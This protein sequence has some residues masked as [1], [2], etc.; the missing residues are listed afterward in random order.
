MA[1]KQKKTAARKQKKAK[2]KKPDIVRGPLGRAKKRKKPRPRHPK[3]APR[4]ID[5]ISAI[6]EAYVEVESLAQEM[7]DWAD[8]MEDKLSGTQKYGEVNDAADTLE[9]VTNPVQAS[10]PGDEAH[11]DF[12]KKVKITIQDPTPRARGFSRSARCGQATDLLEQVLTTLENFDGTEN[13]KE[14]ADELHREIDDHISEL[15]GVSFPGM[16][17]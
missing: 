8:S 9:N 16:Y 3:P 15:Q 14:K 2:A 7:R 17:G 4:E 12:L 5:V 13:E 10:G 6:E 1:K 11:Y